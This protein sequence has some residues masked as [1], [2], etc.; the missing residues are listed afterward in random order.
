VPTE[1]EGVVGLDNDGLGNWGGFFVV[2]WS[3]SPQ[4]HEEGSQNRRSGCCDECLSHCD[5]RGNHFFAKGGAR[6]E[7]QGGLVHQERGTIRGSRRASARGR[8]SPGMIAGTRLR[9]AE[10]RAY[11]SASMTGSFPE[12]MKAT[13]TDHST[14]DS[15]GESYAQRACGKFRLSVAETPGTNNEKTHARRVFFFRALQG[16][17][18]A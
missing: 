12:A 18:A 1:W 10:E 15:R 17:G 11:L 9:R 16:P 13:R 14:M 6:L 4:I 5:R 7:G 2:V 8:T 3:G